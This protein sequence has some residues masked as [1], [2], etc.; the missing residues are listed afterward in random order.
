MLL[1]HRPHRP[2]PKPRQTEAE[3]RELQ[4]LAFAV[5]SHPLDADG[6]TQ[7]AFRDGRAMA[8]VAEAFIK[9]NDRLT[10]IERLAIYNRQYW[11][12]LLDCLWDDYPGL[13]AILGQEKFELLRIAYLCAYPSRSF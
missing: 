6:Q 3:L 5:I 8:D 1:R 4:R 10:A 11:M 12:R 9:P 7:Q 13:R 2:A